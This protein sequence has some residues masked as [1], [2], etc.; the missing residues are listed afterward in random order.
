[1]SKP[2]SPSPSLLA[3]LEAL[4]NRRGSNAAMIS[5]L[6]LALGYLG[7]DLGGVLPAHG[8]PEPECPS[9]PACPAQPAVQPP[10][11]PVVA[12]VAE[13]APEPVEVA[14]AP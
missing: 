7:V 12:P 11:A 9:C 13:P 4:L 3:S 10:A 5:A 1:M 2:P 6:V 8:H 14:P